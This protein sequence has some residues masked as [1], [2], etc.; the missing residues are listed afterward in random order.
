MHQASI[1]HLSQGLRICRGRTR[2]CPKTPPMGAWQTKHVMVKWV[3]LGATVVAGGLP[4]SPQRS[5]AQGQI[6]PPEDGGT[7]LW[8]I[9]GVRAPSCRRRAFCADES[10][11][12]S[13]A[14]ESGTLAD[15]KK[16]KLPSKNNRHPSQLIT[17]KLAGS[18]SSH[19]GCSSCSDRRDR[20]ARARRTS[21]RTMAGGVFFVQWEELES[22][23]EKSTIVGSCSLHCENCARMSAMSSS[24]QSRKTQQSKTSIMMAN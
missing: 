21:L 19:G 3:K 20:D 6:L 12:Q 10:Q 24:E 5:I 8:S 14:R 15:R 9:W 4:P 13:G 2:R 16:P 23:G 11:R 7:E 17:V 18:A 1:P 22:S